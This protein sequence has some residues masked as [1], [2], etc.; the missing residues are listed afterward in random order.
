MDRYVCKSNFDSVAQRLCFCLV[1]FVVV[2]VCLFAIVTVY[3]TRKVCDVEAV[4]VFKRAGK[5][6][7]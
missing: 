7:S 4:S 5:M 6:A 3:S 1:Y 2:V